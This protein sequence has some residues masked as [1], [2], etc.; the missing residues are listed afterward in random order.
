MKNKIFYMINWRLG[1]LQG[2]GGKGLGAG[3]NAGQYALNMSIIIKHQAMIKAASETL[4]H[5][6]IFKL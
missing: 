6:T 1:R 3:E 5:E 2:A 4:H